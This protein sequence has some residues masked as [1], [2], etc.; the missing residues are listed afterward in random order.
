MPA[1]K[2]VARQRILALL[3]RKG[4]HTKNDIMGLLELSE[5]A[6][7]RWLND[8][9][10]DGEVYVSAFCT[11]KV[12]PPAKVYS[13]GQGETPKKP[14]GTHPPGRKEPEMT[15]ELS[16]QIAAETLARVRASSA[17]AFNPFAALIA[18]VA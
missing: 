14:K 2:S 16:A 11:K 7:R 1:L 8:A 17:G 3:K 4:P 6:V 10:R 12:G 15:A 9:Q 5:T 13:I 18:Q